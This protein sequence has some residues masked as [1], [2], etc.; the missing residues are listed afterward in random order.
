MIRQRL[1]PLLKDV[2]EEEIPSTEVTLWPG[3]KERL[4]IQ[5]FKKGALTNRTALRLNLAQKAA[6]VSIL[7]LGGITCALG[8]PKIVRFFIRAN[9]DEFPV[10]PWQTTPMSASESTRFFATV[11]ASPGN[12]L[13]AHLTISEAEKQAGFHVLKPTVLFDVVSTFVGANYDPTR[14]IAYLFYEGESDDLSGMK[15]YFSL[16]LKE[17]RAPITD[18][19]CYWHEVFCNKVGAGAGIETVRIGDVKGE[20]VEGTWAWVLS[21]SRNDNGPYWNSTPFVKTMRWQANG[22][23]FELDYGAQ[24]GDP[25]AITREYMV[26]IAASI[27]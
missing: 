23:F 18:D 1:I 20:Y 27:Q 5:L 14:K 25:D 6:F 9:E 24:G 2:A 11:N 26:E 21:D 7:I 16:V 12:K 22:M 15:N 10:Q 13:N 4:V 17:A 19:Y 3:I 8:A